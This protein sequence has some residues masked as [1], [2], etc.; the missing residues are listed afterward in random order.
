M[1]EEKKKERRKKRRKKRREVKKKRRKRRRKHKKGKI[2]LL[3]TFPQKRFT[4]KTVIKSILFRSNHY[5]APLCWPS[6]ISA[7]AELV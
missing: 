5:N 2:Y 4:E 1:E 6:L 7:P 3:Q